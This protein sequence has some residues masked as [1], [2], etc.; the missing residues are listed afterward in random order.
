VRSSTFL[1]LVGLAYGGA[2]LFTAGLWDFASGNT[3]RGTVFLSYSGLPVGYV[4][5]FIPFFNI[6][7]S[8]SSSAEGNN[9]IGHFL[10]GTNFLFSMLT[11]RLGGFLGFDD[12]GFD[13]TKRCGS[14]YVCGY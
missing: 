13:S 9:A 10:A 2:G 14:G 12:D 4:L 3:S 6:Q 8:F 5:V 7:A 1:T 11:C